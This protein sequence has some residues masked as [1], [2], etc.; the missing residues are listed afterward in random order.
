MRKIPGVELKACMLGGWECSLQVSQGE[1]WKCGGGG[2]PRVS[3]LDGTGL[4]YLSSIPPIRR[5]L[6]S[7]R[8]LPPKFGLRRASYRDSTLS[9]IL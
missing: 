1:R 3:L 7:G 5:P 2:V 6:V 8:V 4:L 9:K